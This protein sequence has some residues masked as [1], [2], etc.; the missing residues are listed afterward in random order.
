M[1]SEHSACDIV[2]KET[3][4]TLWQPLWPHSVRLTPP[5]ASLWQVRPRGSGQRWRSTKSKATQSEKPYN[6][7]PG[8]WT[9]KELNSQWREAQRRLLSR[10]SDKATKVPC[11]LTVR[12]GRS[13]PRSKRQDG[14]SQCQGS[15]GPELGVLEKPRTREA[16]IR[17]ARREGANRGVP[18]AQSCRGCEAH[19][20]RGFCLDHNRKTL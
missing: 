19:A 4:S 3:I 8:I 20:V 11:E 9:L 13:W 12:T 16:G 6:P 18:R 14:R 15:R 10:L 7:D 17:R 1:S 2:Y 5:G